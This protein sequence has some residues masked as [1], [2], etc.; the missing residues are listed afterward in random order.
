MRNIFNYRDHEPPFG[1]TRKCEVPVAAFIR[2][3][4]EVSTVHQNDR[5]GVGR[6][7]QKTNG[8]VKIKGKEMDKQE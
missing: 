5:S 3:W 6:E 1:S 8:D 7:K 2:D 4:S